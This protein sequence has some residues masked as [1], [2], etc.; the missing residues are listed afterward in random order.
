MW[1]QR[2]TLAEMQYVRRHGPLQAVIGHAATGLAL[3]LLFVSVLYFFDSTVARLLRED[4]GLTV[5]ALLFGLH[6]ALFACASFATASGG[7]AHLG[8]G[9]V[10][11]RRTV[12]PAKAEAA[13]GAGRV[14]TVRPKAAP[15]S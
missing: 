8:G 7:S 3:A 14:T 12:R 11:V 5:L 6:A 10:V 2:L 4:G 13:L 9:A 15:N 1:N